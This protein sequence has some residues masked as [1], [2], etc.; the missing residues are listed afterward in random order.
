M[1]TGNNNFG[2]V[3]SRRLRKLMDDGNF[4]QAQIADAC[5]VSQPAVKKWLANSVPGGMEFYL[6]TQKLGVCAEFMLFEDAPSQL[7]Q[8]KAGAHAV[9][10]NKIKLAKLHSQVEELET[11]LAG[12]KLAI[13]ELEK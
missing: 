1:S 6:L 13:K 5:G 7:P 4:T 9:G 3:F 11:A 8:G 12:V 2:N 10:P